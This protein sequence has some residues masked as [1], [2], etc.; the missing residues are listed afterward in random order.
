MKRNVI[1]KMEAAINKMAKQAKTAEDKLAVAMAQKLLSDPDPDKAFTPR[2]M[3]RIAKDVGI[4]DT[5]G[6][7]YYTVQ[8]RNGAV[9]RWDSELRHVTAA[10]LA[11]QRPPHIAVYDIVRT[12][13]KPVSRPVERTERHKGII[14]STEERTAQIARLDASIEARKARLEREAQDAILGKEYAIIRDKNGRETR[15]AWDVLR[16]KQPSHFRTVPVDSRPHT[17]VS[18]SLSPFWST[19]LFELSKM[20][21]VS[22]G[23][24]VHFLSHDTSI[25]DRPV[26]AQFTPV[27]PMNMNMLAMQRKYEALQHE[28]DLHGPYHDVRGFGS[29]SRVR[30]FAADGPCSVYPRQFPLPELKEYQFTRESDDTL[31]RYRG[32]SEPSEAMK[33]FD[34]DSAWGFNR[35]AKQ[36][37]MAVP[38]EHMRG[39]RGI[40]TEQA[41]PLP[42]MHDTEEDYKPRKPHTVYAVA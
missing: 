16:A 33:Q 22:M 29:P 40:R 26:A 35:D 20:K 1:R 8:T 2:L 13:P 30:Y 28:R 10:L 14:R 19:V 25:A 5:L 24:T 15:I 39:M 23:T 12:A 11:A 27:N 9:V 17:H 42:P 4:G 34:P 21:P 31:Q 7:S 38:S 3:K 37:D 18:E 32:T 41:A 6:G 36:D